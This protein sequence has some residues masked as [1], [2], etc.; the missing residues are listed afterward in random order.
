MNKI[1]YNAMMRKLPASMRNLPITLFQMPSDTVFD[2][3]KPVKTNGDEILEQIY[4][5]DSRTKLPSSDIAVFLG[6]NTHPE[7][8]EYI[9]NNLMSDTR[10]VNLGTAGVDDDVIM[11]LTRGADEPAGVYA[12]RVNKFIVD[13]GEKIKTYVSLSQRSA[14]NK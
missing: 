11:A 3:P 2:L 5:L 9:K 10:P 6:E 12:Q 7:I 13:N 1:E 8:K 14:D 4:G